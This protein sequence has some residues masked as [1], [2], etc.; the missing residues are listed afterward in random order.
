MPPGRKKQARLDAAARA[1]QARLSKLKESFEEEASSDGTPDAII[2]SDSEDD[3][4]DGTV[5]HY[6]SS[7]SE[8]CW[9]DIDDAESDEDGNGGIEELAG[10]ELHASID[11]ELARELDELAREVAERTGGVRWKFKEIAT[12]SREGCAR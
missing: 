3:R 4:W 6:P 8:F 11:A 5:N 1:R 10:E 12:A 9:T 7:D 2:I